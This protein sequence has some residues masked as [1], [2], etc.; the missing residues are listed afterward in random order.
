M[1]P[2]KKTRPYHHGDLRET[3]IAAAAEIIEQGGMASFT[4]REC[5]RRAGVSHAAPANHFASTEDLL[6]EVAARGFERFVAALDKAA[7][8]EA[9]QSAD[10]RLMAMGRAYIAFARA[11]PGVYGLMFRNARAFARSE[12]LM[13]AS[14]AAWN[15]LHEMVMQVTGENRDATR[16]KAAHVWAVVHGVAS[17]LIDGRLPGGD[18]ERL[19]AISVASIPAAIKAVGSG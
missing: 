6:A 13:R 18:P 19:I 5:A 17:L 3:L 2:R 1:A 4:L 16:H 8:A 9:V 11:N 10:Q 15:Q 12:H 7:D 14:A